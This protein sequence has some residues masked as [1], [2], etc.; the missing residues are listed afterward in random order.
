MKFGTVIFCN[1]TKKLVEIKIKIAA[2]ATMTSLIKSIVL[3][4]V[5]SSCQISTYLHFSIFKF[6][7]LRGFADWL[8]GYELQKV[9]ISPFK[10]KVIAIR[11][12]SYK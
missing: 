3:V 1:V 8:I 11:F 6:I 9:H 2:I 5:V 10:V 7:R 12:Y 4:A